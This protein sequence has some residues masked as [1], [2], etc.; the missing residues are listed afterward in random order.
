MKHITK[1]LIICA[2]LLIQSSGVFSQKDTLRIVLRGCAIDALRLDSCETSILFADSVI[3]I[4]LK[5]REDFYEVYYHQKEQIERLHEIQWTYVDQADILNQEI[6][7]EESFYML[8]KK[9]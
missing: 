4:F 2:L 3:R 8:L 1:A 7:K 6:K 5:Q 9:V